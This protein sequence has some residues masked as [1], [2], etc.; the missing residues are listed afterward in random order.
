M[1]GYDIA[2]K[3]SFELRGRQVINCAGPWLRAVATAFDQ[4]VGHLF[5]PVLACNVLLNRPAPSDAAVA[6]M[7]PRAGG[8][9][10][11]LIPCQGRCLAGTEYRAVDR[12][13]SIPTADRVSPDDALIQQLLDNLNSVIDLRVSLPDVIRVDAGLLPG[14]RPG[15]E[16]L[17]RR[18]VIHFHDRSGGPRG[19]VSVSGIKFT[20]AR[21]VA[22]AVLRRAGH[23]QAAVPLDR[24]P[25]T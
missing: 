11:F 5:H 1:R 4:D 12:V 10:Y 20:T 8:R 9:A 21:R 19:L 24:E 25:V 22:A 2:E 15:S 17:A 7:S 13:H 6:A 16:R 23:V 14:Q 18:P 3:R